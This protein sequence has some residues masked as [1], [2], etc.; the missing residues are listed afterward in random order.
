[1][2]KKNYNT[3]HIYKICCLDPDIEDCY[4]GSTT[5]IY[6]R[7]AVH[8]SRANKM[9]PGLLFETINKNGG[10]RN[11]ILVVLEKLTVV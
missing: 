8:K 5:N 7:K 9:E 10:W 2:P 1:M 11:W 3:V 4:V 6:T